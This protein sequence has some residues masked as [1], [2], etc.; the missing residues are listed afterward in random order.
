MCNW[1]Q[2]LRSVWLSI[3]CIVYRVLDCVITYNTYFKSHQASLKSETLWIQELCGD[4]NFY[5]TSLGFSKTL[6]FFKQFFSVH[7][8]NFK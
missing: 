6:P 8:I 3:Q 5:N 2:W 1:I 4:K 7:D